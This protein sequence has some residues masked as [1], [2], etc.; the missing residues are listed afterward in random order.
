[1]EKENKNKEE[2]FF[3]DDDILDEE[4]TSEDESDNDSQE[5]DEQDSRYSKKESGLVPEASL[6]KWKKNAKQSKMEIQRLQNEINSL[7]N[8]NSSTG[9]AD[10]NIRQLAEQEGL[11]ESFVEKLVGLT[12]NETE[13]LLSSQLEEQRKQQ[14]MAKV[15]QAFEKEFNKL[16]E[17][18]P[19]MDSKKEAIKQLAFSKPYLKK[20]LP[21]IAEEVFGFNAKA[22]SEDDVISRS[23]DGEVRVDFEEL[24]KNPEKRSKVFEKSPEARQK[25]YD[26][27]D[28]NGY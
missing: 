13:K 4:D 19:E 3:E 6:I 10:K 22:S 14:E 16:I 15:E 25:F 9:V 1:M 20:S 21:E 23:E 28:K 24:R 26:W 5:D 2:V 27:A 7:K 18:F 12:K 17:N 11:S 8:N